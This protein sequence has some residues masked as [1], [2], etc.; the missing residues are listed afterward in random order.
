MKV[1]I[2]DD[3]PIVIQGCAH[4]L[5]DA[6]VTEFIGASDIET[7][8][9]LFVE[10]QP[11]VVILDLA[12][13]SDDHGLQFIRQLRQEERQT[14]IIVFSVHA[15]P[16]LVVTAVRLGAS[17]YVLKDSSARE[18]V[19]AFRSA[20][21]GERYMSEALACELAF[22]KVDAYSPERNLTQRELDT[23]ALVA[24]GK[25]RDVI[26]AELKISKTTVVHTIA[27]LKNKLDA[28]SL[29]DLVRMAV[30]IRPAIN[31]MKAP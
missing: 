14:P 30:R 12:M 2:V 25:T 28:P 10:R 21:A 9:R 27:A 31:G 7:G 19:A 6:G 26:A 23:L 15:D 8:Y 5:E 13:E 11:D 24:E 22:A 29:N 1:L 17:A 3:H 20:I 16:A 4:L 18:F